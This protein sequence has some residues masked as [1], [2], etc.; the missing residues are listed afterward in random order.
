MGGHQAGGDDLNGT[1]VREDTFVIDRVTDP[2]LDAIVEIER[3]SFPL[4]WTRQAFV[5]EMSRPFAHVD[6]LR[7]DQGA[8]VV[9]YCNYWIVHDELQ[10]L[11]V[12]IHPGQRK[13]GAGSR[14]LAHMIE[15][16]RGR[17]CRQILLEV[18]RSNEAAQRLYRRF[19]FRSV[20][21]RP[22]Y[23]VDNQEDA[24]LMTLGLGSQ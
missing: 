8:N 7:N 11:N 2:D 15:V 22:G 3:L 12:A 6:V 13:T 23:Y 5:D 16:A 21:V 19:A 10:I 9:G 17:R 20:G 14:L 1:V 4:P 18:R 24:V